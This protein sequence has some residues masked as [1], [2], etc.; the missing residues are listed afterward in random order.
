MFMPSN[1]SVSVFLILFLGGF[2]ASF[3]AYAQ[4]YQKQ[5]L[6]E[7]SSASITQLS[8]INSEGNI[9]IVMGDSR[10]IRFDVLIQAFETNEA[11]AQNILD[12]AQIQF[13]GS[14]N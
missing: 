2:L 3:S 9:D 8:I 4:P 14:T 10:L 6:K 5:F 7:I 12:H 1:R 11:I 13:E